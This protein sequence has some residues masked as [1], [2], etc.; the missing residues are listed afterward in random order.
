MFTIQSAKNKMNYCGINRYLFYY[1]SF[2]RNEDMASL[3]THI[4]TCK[5]VID[6]NSGSP[7]LPVYQDQEKTIRLYDAFDGTT[8]VCP[9]DGDDSGSSGSDSGWSGSSSAWPGSGSGWSGSGS[10]GSSGS[11]SENVPCE[12]L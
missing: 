9:G 1:A 3:K 12:L 5:D 11:G 6:S 7:F 8:P 4:D 2:F 10:E